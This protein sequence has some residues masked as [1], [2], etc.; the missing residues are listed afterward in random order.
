MFSTSDHVHIMYYV[1]LP[2]DITMSCVHLTYMSKCLMRVTDMSWWHTGWHICHMSYIV[3]KRHDI[4]R[5]VTWRSSTGYKPNFVGSNDIKWNGL[6]LYS[7]WI[8]IIHIL[9]L[10]KVRTIVTYMRTNSCEKGI[11][12]LIRNNTLCD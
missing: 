10:Q 11:E 9:W 2:Q 8:W 6:G 12:Y 4:S 5:D 7:S 3:H 1:W